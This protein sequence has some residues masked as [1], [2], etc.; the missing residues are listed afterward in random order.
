MCSVFHLRYYTASIPKPIDQW[1]SRAMFI[2]AVKR[3]I[4]RET[5]FGG[6]GDACGFCCAQL[7]PD[8]EVSVACLGGCRAW[9]C[10][11][12]C[13]K[14]AAPAHVRS[15]TVWIPTICFARA[16]RKTFFGDGGGARGSLPFGVGTGRRAEGAADGGRACDAAR[17]ID[18]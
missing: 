13:R 3:R 9:Y 5:G 11:A 1:V 12:W 6:D 14:Q 4:N 10:D 2:E 16:A 15:C 7:M 8:D 17:G 18:G